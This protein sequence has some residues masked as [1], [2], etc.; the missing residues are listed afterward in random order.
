MNK[1]QAG[2]L[3]TTLT[4]IGAAASRGKR[5]TADPVTTL[6][7]MRELA[8]GIIAIA[9][10]MEAAIDGALGA[11]NVLRRASYPGPELVPV[12]NRTDAP[13]PNVTRR[14]VRR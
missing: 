2:I 13:T 14:M 10:E 12:P 8:R 3:E 11:E 4:R 1:I 9:S 6:A 5:M 7:D